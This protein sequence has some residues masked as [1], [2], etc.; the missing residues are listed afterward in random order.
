MLT[1]ADKYQVVDKVSALLGWP[2][3]DG[4]GEDEIGLD[5]DHSSL[6]KFERKDSQAFDAVIK[7]IQNM[8]NDIRELPKSSK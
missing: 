8:V 1:V 3:G 2:K 6:C 4:Q 7:P 5:E